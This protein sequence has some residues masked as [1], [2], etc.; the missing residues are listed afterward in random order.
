MPQVR[1]ISYIINYKKTNQYILSVLK[2]I[3]RVKNN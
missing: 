3:Q 1:Y 2:N